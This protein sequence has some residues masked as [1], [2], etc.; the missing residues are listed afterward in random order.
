M[1]FWEDNGAPMGSHVSMV[2]FRRQA[3]LLQDRDEQPL[4]S[5]LPND[6]VGLAERKVQRKKSCGM[7]HLSTLNLKRGRAADA[8]G[9]DLERALRGYH[10]LLHSATS[11]PLRWASR[12]S[13][14]PPTCR[15]NGCAQHVANSLSSKLKLVGGPAFIRQMKHL[16]PRQSRM[17]RCRDLPPWIQTPLDYRTDS[18][19]RPRGPSSLP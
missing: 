8:D 19:P 14:E 7:R 5:M 18:V 4:P 11:T 10:Q 9:D 2:L 1:R 15:P 6:A 3:S 17:H 13:Q 12:S 16:A